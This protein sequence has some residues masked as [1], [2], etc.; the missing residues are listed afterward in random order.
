MRTLHH[1]DAVG[2]LR[3]SGRTAAGHRTYDAAELDRLQQ[4]LTCRELGFALAE[5]RRQSISR[6]F[7]DCD[8]AMHTRLADLYVVD[9]RF[10]AHYERRAQGLAQVVHDAVHANT[11]GPDGARR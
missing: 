7:Y 3:P 1:W 2:V 5:V 11:Q 10:A 6:N 8:L 4:V 9:E